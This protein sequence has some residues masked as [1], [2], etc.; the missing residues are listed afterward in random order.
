[1][2]VKAASASTRASRCL[3]RRLQA[4]AGLRVRKRGA[5]AARP[6]HLGLG[7]VSGGG[8]GSAFVHGFRLR[9]VLIDVDV[10]LVVPGEGDVEVILELKPHRAATLDATSTAVWSDFTV[11]SWAD[12]QTLRQNCSRLIV[13]DY[14]APTG[15]GMAVERMLEVQEARETLGA[16]TRSAHVTT[17]HDD[18]YTHL[19]TYGLSYGPAYVF[20]KFQNIWTTR[21]ELMAEILGETFK[22]IRSTRSHGRGKEV[23]VH[24]AGEDKEP[25]CTAVVVRAAA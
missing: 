20:I 22:L 4:L 16:M 17:T 23:G 8:S 7:A 13:V 12:G 9:D 24:V 5:M 25:C 21:P 10:A 15:S 1:M 2:L 6:Q 3:E 19:D 11:A 14:E 18:L